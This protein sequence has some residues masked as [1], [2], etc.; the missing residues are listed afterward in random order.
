MNS[1]SGVS[2]TGGQG[3]RFPPFYPPQVE[4]RALCHFQSCY[5]QVLKTAAIALLPSV[6]LKREEKAG[7]HMLLKSMKNN[8]SE[9]SFFSIP[10]KNTSHF[11]ER[12]ESPTSQF[13]M[14]RSQTLSVRCSTCPQPH[15]LTA[16]IK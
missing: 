4:I 6:Y 7:S 15:L 3:K 2:A 16:A 12:Q 8:Y 5:S 14:S 11:L 1:F 9:T 10:Y 13:Q